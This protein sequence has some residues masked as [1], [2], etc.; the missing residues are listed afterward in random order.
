MTELYVTRSDHASRRS[1]LITGAAGAGGRALVERLASKDLHARHRPSVIVVGQR[2]Q[3]QN[4]SVKVVP[5]SDSAYRL[6]LTR[7]GYNAL[8]REV[9]TVV[10]VA[11][12]SVAAGTRGINRRAA[13]EALDLAERA[14]AHFYYVCSAFV[15][16]ASDVNDPRSLQPETAAEGVL[17]DVIRSSQ[18]PHSV[19]R[20]SLVIGDSRTGKI[21]EFPA[22]YQVI[23]AIFRGLFPRV[24]LDRRWLLDCIP[25]DI[26]AD[27]IAG[28]IEYNVADREVWVTN[29][30]R[31]LSIEQV[32]EVVQAHAKESGRPL[33]HPVVGFAGSRSPVVDPKQRAQRRTVAALVDLYVTK[34]AHTQPLESSLGDRFQ[35]S[36]GD[37]GSV[38][39]P[40]LPDPHEALLASLRYWGRRSER[41]L[42]RSAI[43]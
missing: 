7:V 23:D 5:G 42:T 18:V 24:R 13:G 30:E 15:N 11:Y 28:L 26:V 33:R 3:E 35:N 36:L 32:S 37:L 6:G 29:G 38:G 22:I 34:L 19:I 17:Q 16:N 21:K 20:T 4:P 43:A 8:A 31:A 9:R 14:G 1:V 27:V 40:T 2:R 41:E 10:H 12:D 25:C 39:L